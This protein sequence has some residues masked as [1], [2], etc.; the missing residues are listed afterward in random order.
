MR[1]FYSRR[2]WRRLITGERRIVL[3]TER[4]KLRPLGLRDAEALFGITSL[5]AVATHLTWPP[6]T[7]IRQARQL[8]WDRLPMLSDE[9]RYGFAV[10]LKETQALIGTVDFLVKADHRVGELHSLYHPDY[11]G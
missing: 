3:E 7:H 5:P 2:F 9:A 10:V 4:L 6:H 8:I 11:W 1:R